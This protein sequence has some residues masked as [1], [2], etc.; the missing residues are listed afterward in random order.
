M[1]D[2]IIAAA[3]GLCREQIIIAVDGRCAAGKTTLAAALERRTECNVFHMDDFFLRR[4]QRTSA[5]YAAPGENVDHER[6]LSEVLLPL[7]AKKRFCYRP[8]DPH[9]VGFKP[10]IEVEPKPLTVVEGSYCCHS[11]LV[12]HYDLRIF[13]D[14]SPEAQMR[15]II[16]RNGEAVA[17]MFESRWI[18]LEE[19]Y[20]NAF[21]VREKCELYYKCED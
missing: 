15:R 12:R 20:F 1:L 16:K 10:P 5:R 19:A 4:E 21:G 7:K 6:F 17:K 14:I 8:Y 13:M 9:G 11:E 3:N 18:P 2:E